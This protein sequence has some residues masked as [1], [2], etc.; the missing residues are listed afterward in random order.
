LCTSN[1]HLEL[2]FSHPIRYFGE[3]SKLYFLKLFSPH[4]NLR[5]VWCGGNDAIVVGQS[6][7]FLISLFVRL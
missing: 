1:I 2:S 3:F 4:T 7:F 5:I 6:C